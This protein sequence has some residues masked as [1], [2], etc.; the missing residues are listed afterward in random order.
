MRFNEIAKPATP[1]RKPSDPDI[2]G[3]EERRVKKTD[4]DS[5]IDAVVAHLKGQRSAY[6]TR[7]ARRFGRAARIKKLLAAEEKTLKKE[8]LDAVDAIFDKGDEVYTRVVETASLVFKISKSGQK[9]VDKLDQAGYLKELEEL[10]GLALNELQTIKDKYTKPVTSKIP[11]KVL[12]P[13]E[14]KQ[15]KESMNEGV[16]DKLTQFVSAVSNKIEGF[17]SQWDRRFN[18]VKSKIEAAMEFPELDDEYMSKFND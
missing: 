14:K 15:P 4:P 13:T 11:P 2:T 8:T 10:T 9:T 16:M 18:D 7:I 6:F 1:G 3:Y 17:L 5:D 12:A